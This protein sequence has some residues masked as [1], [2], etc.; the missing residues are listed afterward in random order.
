MWK[1][2]NQLSL[3]GGSRG[4]GPRQL[5]VP[6]DHTLL[7]LYASWSR[8][9]SLSSDPVNTT[10]DKSASS[11][12]CFSKST[13]S[14]MWPW[15]KMTIS[16][17][18]RLRRNRWRVAQNKEP[19][20]Q[21]QPLNDDAHQTRDRTVSNLAPRCKRHKKNK[22]N[23]DGQKPDICEEQWDCGLLHVDMRN[24]R[25]W[26]F[27]HVS[28]TFFSL[29]LRSDPSQCDEER[30]PST[31][32]RLAEGFIWIF[33]KEWLSGTSVQVCTESDWIELPEGAVRS[34]LSWNKPQLYCSS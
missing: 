12:A 16:F 1:K 11:P 18:A 26:H 27:H 3:K 28:A 7:W 19:W 10:W 25:R 15:K 30:I 33:F 9:S 2:C 17:K 6:Q 24:K 4:W 5:L 31:E 13:I 21:S 20:R 23:G 32:I 34:V 22:T 29:I 14:K 8:H